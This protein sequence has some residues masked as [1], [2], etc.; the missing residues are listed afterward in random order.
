LGG[1]E[2]CGVGEQLTMQLNQK[3]DC[4]LLITKGVAAAVH[5]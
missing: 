2:R 4:L 3:G 5:D 1:I